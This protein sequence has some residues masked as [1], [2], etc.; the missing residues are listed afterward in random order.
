M[1]NTRTGLL[2]L[3]L[4]AS[5]TVGAVWGQQAE[6]GPRSIAQFENESVKVWKS[7]F[8]PGQPTAMHRHDHPSVIAVLKGGTLKIVT[9]NGQ[10]RSQVWETGKAYW[11]PANPPDELHGLVNEGSEPIEVMTIELEKEQ[12]RSTSGLSGFG[13]N[14]PNSP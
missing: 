7:V 8:L 6:T 12:E 2:I 1:Q 13:R 14:A 10:S 3:G 4:A 5:F 11:Q 9:G